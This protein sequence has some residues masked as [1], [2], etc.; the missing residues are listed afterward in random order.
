MDV[1]LKR[2]KE[3][4]GDKYNFRIEISPLN[5]SVIIS[6]EMWENEEYPIVLEDGIVHLDVPTMCKN[7]ID[8]GKFQKCIPMDEWDYGFN[9]DIIDIVSKIMTVIEDNEE[10]ISDIV[11]MCNK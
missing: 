7:E 6:D 3:I 5:F 1:I 2:I 8:G 11:S 9:H 4:L 10:Y